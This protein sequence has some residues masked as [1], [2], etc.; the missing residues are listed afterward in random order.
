MK[1]LLLFIAV[2]GISTTYAQTFAEYI[3][4]HRETTFQIPPASIY[5]T[6]TIYLHDHEKMV[7]EMT[8]ITDYTMLSDLDS[9]LRV[10]LADAAFYKDSVTELQNVRI[11]YDIKLGSDN[12]IMR[13]KKYNPDGDIYVKQ[14]GKMSRMKIARDTFRIIFRKPLHDHSSKMYLYDYP[15]QVTFLMNNYTNLYTL[16]Q[17]KG[18]LQQT[19]DTLAKSTL[20]E[21]YS[22]RLSQHRTEVEYMPYTAYKTMTIK[23]DDTP[24][25]VSK[26]EG[27]YIKKIY[28]QIPAKTDS[29]HTH[30]Q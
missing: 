15:V 26:R 20:P 24:T 18:M 17:D 4:A 9:V 22:P 28:D 25:A 21:R 6:H 19:I 7:I 14:N 11:D 16:L 27:K 13:F 2:L 1:K 12:T 8:D 30:K 29:T 10:A 3:N 23:R 5:H